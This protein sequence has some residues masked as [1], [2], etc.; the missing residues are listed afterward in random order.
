MDD[1]IGDDLAPSRPLTGLRLLLVEDEAMIAMDMEDLISDLGAEV[2]GPFARLR[3]ALHALKHEPI[4]GAVLDI[5]LDHET[6]FP[7]ADALL[8]RADPLIFV[9]GDADDSVPEKY[10]RLPR[11]RKPLDYAE[12]TRLATSV[13]D[14]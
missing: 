4:H 13:F 7:L 2:V 3:D 10:R 11:L 5:H 12:F 9:S 6:T 1:R 14:A 8:E